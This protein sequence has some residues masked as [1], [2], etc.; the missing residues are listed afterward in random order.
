MAAVPWHWHLVLGNLAFCAVFQATEPVSAAHTDRGRWV[1]AVFIGFLTVLIRVLNPAFP[2]G[3][4]LAILF[5]NLVA[6]LLD[7]ADMRLNMR[8]RAIRD[9]QA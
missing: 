6:P 8:R 2:E 5:G 9:A 1:Y 4:M 7:Y 3:V